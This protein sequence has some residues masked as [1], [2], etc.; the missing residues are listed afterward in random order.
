MKLPAVSVLI[1]TVG[2]F[3]G[4]TVAFAQSAGNPSGNQT[5]QSLQPTTGGKGLGY[6]SPSVGVSPGVSSSNPGGANPPTPGSSTS[7]TSSA[8]SAS[9]GVA[10]SSNP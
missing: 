3:V 10:G 5:T 4:A 8:G 1:V 6:S 9:S 7:G 2:S